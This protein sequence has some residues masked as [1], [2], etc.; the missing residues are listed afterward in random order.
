[1]ILGRTGEQCSIAGR[2]RAFG[3]YEVQVSL[4]QGDYFPQAGDASDA[5]WILSGKLE[6]EQSRNAAKRYKE[7]YRS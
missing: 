5:F 6:E 4:K 3:N 2:Y 7:R 1:M